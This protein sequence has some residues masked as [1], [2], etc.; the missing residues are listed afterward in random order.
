MELVVLAALLAAVVA[1]WVSARAAVTVCVLE[2]RAGTLRV[3]RGGIATPVLSDV[4][5]VVARPP[6]AH[7]TLRIVRSDG[8]ARLEVNG[9]ISEAQLQQLRNVVG[10]VPLARLASAPRR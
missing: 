10:S 2:V 8:Y 3:V 9:V 1:L 5:D 7:A 6:I 4:A